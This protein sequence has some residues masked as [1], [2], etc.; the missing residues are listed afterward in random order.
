MEYIPQEVLSKIKHKSITHNKFRIQ[1]NES[2]MCEF[3][4]IAVI[5][6]MLAGKTLLAYT[7]SFCPN[8]CKKNDKI[9]TILK[10]NMS[11]PEL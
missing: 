2:I 9:I 4:C 8:D 5:K 3:Y 10:A 7:N 6:Y 11:S 1:D